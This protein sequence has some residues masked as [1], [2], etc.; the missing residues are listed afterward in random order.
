MK[1]LDGKIAIVT[2]AAGGIGAATV[3]RFVQEGAVVVAADIFEEGAQKAVNELG[4]RA[5]S[6]KVDMGDVAS[7]EAMIQATVAKFRRLDVLHN[8]AALQDPA[9]MNKDTSAP[10]IPIEVW[11]ATFRV[12]LKGYLLACKFAI[13]Q[14]IKQRGGVIL[15]T[16]STSGLSA[17][18]NLIAYSASKAGVISLTRTIAV[19]HG[20]Q[21]I[22]CNAIAPGLILTPRAQQSPKGYLEMIAKHVLTPRLGKSE[23]IAALAAFLAS[24]DAEF[25][26]GQTISCDGGYLIH[27]P[28]YSD[29]NA[30]ITGNLSA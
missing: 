18:N 17:D 27:Q 20:R 7:V 3:R 26:T 12:N 9:V 5:I 28:H 19:Q 16:T 29:F 1:R 11:D 15:N 22:R 2:G 24:D 13:P 23:D 21:F 4:G 6:M 8:N 30:W 14:M 10:E 25:I